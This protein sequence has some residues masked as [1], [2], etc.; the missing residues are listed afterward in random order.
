MKNSWLDNFD[1]DLDDD[2]TQESDDEDGLGVGKETTCENVKGY[3][4]AAWAC[5]KEHVA[6]NK[7]R[8]IIDDILD[9]VEDIQLHI[10][11]ENAEQKDDQTSLVQLYLDDNYDFTDDLQKLIYRIHDMKKETETQDQI[12]VCAHIE[13]R[14]M[15]L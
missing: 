2:E 3:F 10:E 14:L 8:E 4:V 7:I 13:N 15:V 9:T 6:D 11:T 1:F 5:K 12:D